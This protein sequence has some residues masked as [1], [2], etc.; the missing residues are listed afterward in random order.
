MSTQKQ[1][2]RLGEQ[3]GAIKSLNWIAR[4]RGNEVV[5]KM[6]GIPGSNHRER[7]NAGRKAGRIEK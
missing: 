4:F 1:I 5:N 2:A 7:G 6:R 3:M